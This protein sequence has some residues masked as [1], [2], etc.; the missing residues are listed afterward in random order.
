MDHQ[1]LLRNQGGR[2]EDCVACFTQRI[3][4]HL[5]SYTGPPIQLS[6]VDNSALRRT[7]RRQNGTPLPKRHPTSLLCLGAIAKRDL[8][9]I[10]PVLCRQHAVTSRVLTLDLACAMNLLPHDFEWAR[11]EQNWSHPVDLLKFCRDERKPHITVRPD[12]QVLIN[13]YRKGW[14]QYQ[15]YREKGASNNYRSGEGETGEDQ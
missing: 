6:S 10:S 5:T 13:D 14:N 3:S 7:A 1:V 2:R 9:S 12:Q 4:V 11:Q 8:Q 15:S